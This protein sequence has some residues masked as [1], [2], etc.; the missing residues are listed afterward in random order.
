[1]PENLE[2]I[3]IALSPKQRRFL[4]RE[5]TR[6]D[7]SVSGQARHIISLAARRGTKEVEH[8]D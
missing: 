4:E 7:R 6:Q 8:A 2:Q 3:T 5:A 1:M